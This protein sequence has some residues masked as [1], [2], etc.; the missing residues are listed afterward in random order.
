VLDGLKEED[1]ILWYAGKA[2]S[3]AGTQQQKTAAV[4]E[5]C[6]LVAQTDDGVKEALYVD[7]LA[8]IMPSKSLWRD[9]LR[10]TRKQAASKPV[11]VSVGQNQ[12][13]GDSDS[14][15][16]SPL[17]ER[18][19]FGMRDGYYYSINRDGRI[20][21]WSN[22]TMRPLFHIKDPVMALRLFEISN[23]YGRTEMVEFRQEDLI[24]LGKFRYN[25]REPGQLPVVS[26]RT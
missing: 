20:R 13:N 21:Q 2:L 15:G 14:G 24:T 7:E 17:M 22:F 16:E 4:M 9:G 19:G 12:G 25:G 6:S 5:V 3:A 18:Y 26:R 23:I 11:A 1:F 10:E 8:R